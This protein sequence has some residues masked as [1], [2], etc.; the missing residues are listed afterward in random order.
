MQNLPH[1]TVTTTF[2]G[3]AA[4]PAVPPDSSAAELDTQFTAEIYSRM[5]ITKLFSVTPSFQFIANP[6][7]NPE[8]NALVLLGLRTRVTL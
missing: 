7:A 3:L 4:G 2:H 8:R 5:Q 6:S 1:T